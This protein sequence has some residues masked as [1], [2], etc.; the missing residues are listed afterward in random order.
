MMISPGQ[1]HE[2]LAILERR[3][4]VIQRALELFLMESGD[5]SADG[6]I[7]AIYYVLPQVNLN[8]MPNVQ[9]YSLLQWTLGYNPHVPGLL[10]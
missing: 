1:A 9:G 2:R 3:D 7:Q 10:P 5:F 4:H 6:I 8:R